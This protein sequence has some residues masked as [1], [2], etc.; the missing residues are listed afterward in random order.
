[1]FLLRFYRQKRL[2]DEMKKRDYG[3][4]LMFDQVNTRYAIDANDTQI[5]SSHYETRCTL[6][7]AV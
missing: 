6:F 4:L 5:W 2:C 1:M 7:F 3:D